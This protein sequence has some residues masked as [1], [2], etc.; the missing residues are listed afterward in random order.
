MPALRVS[1]GYFP[2]KLSRTFA[3]AFHAALHFKFQN[4][5]APESAF[6]N[7]TCLGEKGSQNIYFFLLVLVAFLATFFGVLVFFVVVFFI[8][9][10]FVN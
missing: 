5:R 3:T 7:L 9:I 6:F 1:S 10:P 2:L 4:L 8:R